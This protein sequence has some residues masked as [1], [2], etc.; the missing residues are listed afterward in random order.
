MPP[1]KKGC[2]INIREKVSL[3]KQLWGGD[4]FVDHAIV[5]FILNN[6]NHQV[7]LTAVSTVDSKHK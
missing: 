7:N 6:N 4:I 2:L 1:T 3:M 5:D